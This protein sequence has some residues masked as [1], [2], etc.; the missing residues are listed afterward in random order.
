MKIEKYPSNQI[1]SNAYQFFSEGTRGRYEIR[2]NFSYLGQSL[3]N[4]GFGVWNS[5][6]EEIDDSIEIRNGDM[7]RILA[8]VSQ[9]TFQFLESNSQ[10]I[11]LASGSSTVRTRKYQI[12][13]GQNL[14]SLNS[15]YCISGF[16]ADRDKDGIISGAYPNWIGT[17]SNFEKGRNYDAFLIYL[18]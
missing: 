9:L 1:S 13:I 2:V 7:D 10:V 17:W 16:I 8:T 3:Y 5:D 11:V 6:K 18:L 15:R 12:G 14:D 4:L